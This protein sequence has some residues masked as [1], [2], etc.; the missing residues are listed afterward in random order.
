MVEWKLLLLF[1]RLGQQIKISAPVM[2]N[3]HEYVIILVICLMGFILVY[4]IYLKTFLRKKD[5]KC[6]LYIVFS[7]HIFL[8][9]NI[10]FGQICKIY[11]IRI[12][13]TRFVEQWYSRSY[14]GRALTFELQHLNYK[15]NSNDHENKYT[16][17]D[18]STT[19]IN[20]IIMRVSISCFPSFNTINP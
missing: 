12:F 7:S 5:I 9:T 18:M 6:R 13:G 15:N 2:W 1:C 11:S 20:N 19:Y 14:S 3:Y 8:F 17:N 10:V 16:S 4:C